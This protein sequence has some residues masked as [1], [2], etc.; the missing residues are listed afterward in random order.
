MY[1][2]YD[3]IGNPIKPN[4]DTKHYRR[5]YIIEKQTICGIQEITLTQFGKKNSWN[6]IVILIFGNLLIS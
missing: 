4:K 3:V 1:I 5:G 6:F 2:H